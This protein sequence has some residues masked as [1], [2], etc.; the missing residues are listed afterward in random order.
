M[1]ISWFVPSVWKWPWQKWFN[2]D[3]VLA[4]TWIRC[5]QLIPYLGALGVSSEINKWDGETQIAVFLRRWGKEEQILARRLKTK[6]VKIVIDT[7]VNY[8]SPQRLPAL[9]SDARDEFLSFVD[10]ADAVF[11]PSHYIE[12]YGEKLGYSTFCVED[13]IDFKHFC[14][15]KKDYFS[16]GGPVLI[17]SG[18]S[19]KADTLNFLASVI[20]QNTWHVVIISDKRPCLDFDFTFIRWRYELF[21]RDI[22]EGDIGI[23]PRLVNNEY[24]MGHS[25]FKIG[26]FLAQHVPVICSPLHSY[27]QVTTESNTLCLNELDSEL[28]E[29]G[30]RAFESGDRVIDFSQNPVTNFS[31]D[32]IA[33]KYHRIFLEV[34]EQ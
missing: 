21:P 18:V 33:A 4:S 24:D 34:L 14:Y 30:I 7:P 25:F 32:R 22:L 8:F 31:T 2:Y 3:R 10:I 12:Q 13:S 27:N 16:K 23:F 20:K 9:E 6:G 26:V 11:C 19:V 29:S 5:L 17:W 1:N 28:W 15:R